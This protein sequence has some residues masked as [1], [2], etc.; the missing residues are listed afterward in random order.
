[1][2]FL[3]APR[4]PIRPIGQR[5]LGYETV[6]GSVHIDPVCIIRSTVERVLENFTSTLFCLYKGGDNRGGSGDNEHHDLGSA[7][8]LKLGTMINMGWGLRIST[9]PPVATD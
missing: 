4:L 9:D 6:Q 7:C 5:A 3:I 1:L 2:I 8:Q